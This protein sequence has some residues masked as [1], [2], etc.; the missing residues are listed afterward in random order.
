MLVLA[1]AGSLGSI[2]PAMVHDRTGSYETAFSGYAV[3][4]L[5]VLASLFFVRDERRTSEPG[6]LR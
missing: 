2:Y 6:G 5:L 1:P 3:L 4:M